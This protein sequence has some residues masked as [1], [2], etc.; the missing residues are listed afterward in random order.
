M[1]L[2]KVIKEDYTAL[3]KEELYQAGTIANKILEPIEDFC[4]LTDSGN[5]GPG[6][7]LSR[8]YSIPSIPGGRLGVTEVNIQMGAPK[9]TEII[10]DFFYL[11]G[12]PKEDL[13]QVRSAILDAGLN[14]KP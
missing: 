2:K 8:T 9:I 6:R 1:S 12:S 10:A 4:L 7:S 13:D 5:F 14:Q 11:E 3:P